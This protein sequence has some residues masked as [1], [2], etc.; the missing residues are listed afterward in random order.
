MVNPFQDAMMRRLNIIGDMGQV[1]M[2]PQG[3]SFA[4]QGG[5]SAPPIS[6]TG[7]S[8][9]KGLLDFGHFLQGRG[10][11]VSENPYFGGVT[12]GVHVQNSDHYKGRAI[13]VNFA[14]GTSS[15]EQAAIDAILK[16]AQQY[17][18]K[19][20][21]RQPGHFNHAHFYF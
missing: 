11:R 4:P 17:G 3:Q 6:G 14:P 8:G 12:Q 15:R 5:G 16:Y 21:W 7:E 13:D 18:L 9:M 10:F 19:S 20:I 1:P 2:R